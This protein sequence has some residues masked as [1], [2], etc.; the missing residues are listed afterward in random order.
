MGTFLVL[1]ES[2]GWCE[3]NGIHLR[4]VALRYA[5][6]YAFVVGCTLTVTVNTCPKIQMLMSLGILFQHVS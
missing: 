5:D 6:L 1:F 4:R 3:F 2:A